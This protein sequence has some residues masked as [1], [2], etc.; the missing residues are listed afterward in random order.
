MS[1]W[2][3]TARKV[4]VKVLEENKGRAD[5]EIKKA[6]RDAYPFGIRDPHPYK[7]W[8]DEIKVQTGKRRFGVRKEKPDPNQKEMF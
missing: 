1:M 2:R 8:L 3:D 5:E 7:I 4:I 6:L